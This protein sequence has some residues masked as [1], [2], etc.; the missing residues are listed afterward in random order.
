MTPIIKYLEVPLS[1]DEFKL[2]QL[3]ARQQRK[4]VMMLASEAIVRHAKEV[5]SY[6]YN[7]SFLKRQ[8]EAEARYS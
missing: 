5:V 7:E 2:L 8:K 6:K 4:S 3:A 1:A